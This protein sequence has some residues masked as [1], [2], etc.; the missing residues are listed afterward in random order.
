[1][2]LDIDAVVAKPR[3]MS[4]RELARRYA[5]ILGEQARTRHKAYRIGRIAWR[6]IPD[7]RAGGQLMSRK[8]N[9][10]T[11]TPTVRW[12]I[13]AR[14]STDDGLDQEFNSLETQRDSGG[15]F[16]SS[17]KSEG[18][19]CLPEH[20]DNRGFTGDNMDQPALRRVL[21]D[22][23]AGKVDCVVVYNV[24]RLSRSPLDFAKI[25]KVFKQWKAS[26]VSVTQQFNTA[27]S[28]DRL[29]L[30]VLLSSAHFES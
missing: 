3:A 2:Q 30:N 28:M 14:L 25:M 26:F 8:N 11:S 24:D 9:S 13:H 29:V 15:V 17:Q 20:Y 21:A 12:A 23:D 5:E 19:R 4:T 6:R 22:I 16:I 7:P 10:K 1:M 18:S 27:T